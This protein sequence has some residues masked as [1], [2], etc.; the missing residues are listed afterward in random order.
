M[1][2]WAGRFSK[3]ADSITNDFNS[4]LPFDCRLYKED[5][6]GSIAHSEMLAA[7]GIITAEDGEKIANGLRSILSDIETGKLAFDPAAE[8]I[9]TFVEQ[10]LI[11]RIGDA[12]KRLHTAR[13]RNDQVALD[14]RLYMRAKI[15]EIQQLILS[16]ITE[17]SSKAK[18]T[19]DMIMP[20]Y[21]HMQRAQP[22]TFAHYVLAY[23]Q[24]L[25]RDYERFEDCRKRMDSA[26]PLGSGALAGTT[27]PIDRF[28]TAKLL[29]FA[30]PCENSMD[31]VSDRDFLI[32][33]A[34]AAAMLMMHM[35][36]FCTEIIAWCSMEFS[37]VELDDAFS[38]GSSI[39][40]QKK[41]PDIAELVRG[42]AG[43]VY[44]DLMA[45]ISVMSSIPL[46]YNKDMQED[47][48]RIFDSADTV[49]AC[50]KAFTPMFATMRLKPDN[51][52]N[53]AS[54]GFLNATDF[55]DYL[56]KKGMPFRDAY[57]TVGAAVAYCIEHKKDFSKLS[58]DELKAIEPSLDASLFDAI[59]LERCVNDRRSYGGPAPE[60]VM[61][62][63][64]NLDLFLKQVM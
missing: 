17:I 62:Q 32:E 21:T 6:T 53:A 8:D 5:I 36:R 52:K 39:M 22:V 50:L 48:E 46:A 47:K 13:S 2:L 14:I 11:S 40:P 25:K 41:N 26:M 1:K 56:T 44:G 33:F 4:S 7:C 30:A 9:H 38:T 43:R 63:I 29:D 20:G 64:K 28:M 12:G 24:M 18:T 27:Y 60:A 49:C 19:T 59:S 45:L 54:L 57:K 15:G 37:F 55:A 61:V 3:E 35:S 10:T 23:A 16:L 34:S 58:A 31:G 42:K 51:M